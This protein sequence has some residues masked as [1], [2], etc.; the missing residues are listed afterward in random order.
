MRTPM[1]IAFLVTLTLVCT[2]GR[3]ALATEAT[4]VQ[5]RLHGAYADALPNDNPFGPRPLHFK[6]LLDLIREAMTDPNV[7]ALHLKCESPKLGLA[8]V[9]ELVQAF[10]QFKATGKKIYAFVEQAK[11][12][13][14]LL[15]SVAHRIEMPDSGTVLLSGV[16]AETLYVKDF[17]DKL[18]IKIL[19]TPIG[20]YKT[21]FENYAHSAMSPERREMLE[22]LVE[23]S[24]QAIQEIIAEGR[25]I[26]RAQVAAAIDRAFLSAADLKELGL[27]DAIAPR[28]LFWAGVKADLGVDTLKLVTN[29]GRKTFDFEAQN[30]FALF[31]LLMEA[32]APPKKRT[33]LNPKIA[34]VYAHGIIQ[35]GKSQ[36]SPFG[37]GG[38]MGSETLVDA[39]KTATDDP[40]VH[41]IVLRIDSPGG[42]GIASDAIWRAVVQASA[43]KPVVASMADVAASGGYYIAMGAHRILAEPETLTGSIGVVAVAVNVKGAMDQLGVKVER[44]TRGQHALDLSPFTDSESGAPAPLRQLLEHFYWQ[45]VDKAAQG[46]HKTRADIH[47]V[48]QGRVWTGRDAVAQGLVDE[49]GGLQRALEVARQLAHIAPEDTLEI[50]ELPPPP[51]IFEAFAE[52]FGGTRLTEFSLPELELA[53]TTP[54]LRETLMQTVHLLAAAR[55]TLVALLPVAV[56]LH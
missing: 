21:A 54:E 20:S 32:L 1:F 8:K 38:V 25:G 42:S 52:A 50:L 6:G 4:V 51:K 24:Y 16:S 27:I 30:P 18:G 48:A 22:D 41:A 28:D 44:V 35:S 56:Y 53:L 55:E 17:L 29:Y 43:R 47:A 5:L 7:V 2:P 26:P 39:L 49:L 3:A 15:L 12:V 45:F 40:A 33:T 37:G 46:R 23:S 14:L 36:K 11:L 19:V 9:R 34:L 13:D 31:K 10:Q